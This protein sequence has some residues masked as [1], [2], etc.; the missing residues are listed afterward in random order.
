MI[1]WLIAWKPIVQVILWVLNQFLLATVHFLHR[2]DVW[3]WSL[4]WNEMG[5]TYYESI[6]II[7]FKIKF[8]TSKLHNL[9]TFFSTGASSWSDKLSCR[10]RKWLKTGLI[11]SVCLMINT[12]IYTHHV[13]CTFASFFSDVLTLL[14]SLLTDVLDILTHYDN[15][16]CQNKLLTFLGGN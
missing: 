2:A 7:H 12:I 11:G 9:F 6:C 14:N 5:R 1:I 3:I 4:K 13:V 16:T 15:S 8:H 10:F